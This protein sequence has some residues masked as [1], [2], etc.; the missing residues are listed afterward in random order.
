M[1]CSLLSVYRVPLFLRLW[2]FCGFCFRLWFWFCLSGLLV[3]VDC[4]G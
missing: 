2:S 1:C 3:E 4:I